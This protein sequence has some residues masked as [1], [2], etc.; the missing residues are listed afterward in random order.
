MTIRR[1]EISPDTFEFVGWPCGADT[2]AATGSL[3]ETVA[4]LEQT[5]T[6]LLCTM[7]S[8]RVHMVD[9]SV[10]DIVYQFSMEL[11]HPIGR[12]KYANRIIDT[13]MKRIFERLKSGVEQITL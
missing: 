8:T 10:L 11:D 6:K 9:E 5:H 4:A 12:T 2:I 13:V 1:V 7:S 3:A